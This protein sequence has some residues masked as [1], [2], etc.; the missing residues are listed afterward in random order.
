MER[1]FVVLYKDSEPSTNRVE[2]EEI[3]KFDII[4][5]LFQYLD[6]HR[7]KKVAVYKGKCL[8]DWS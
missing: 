3:E 5:E 4:D 2:V 7:G 6:S 8:V 1:Y